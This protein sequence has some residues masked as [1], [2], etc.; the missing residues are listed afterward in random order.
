M[1]IGDQIAVLSVSAC[2]QG[3]HYCQIIVK[4]AFGDADLVHAKAV[5]HLVEFREANLG[6]AVTF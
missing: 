1:L 4:I 6:K 3:T 5:D 2:K